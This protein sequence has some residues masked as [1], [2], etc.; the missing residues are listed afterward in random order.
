MVEHFEIAGKKIWI[1]TYPPKR[2]LPPDIDVN[3]TLDELIDLPQDEYSR[4]YYERSG[5]FLG[6]FDTREEAD[7]ADPYRFARKFIPGGKLPWE[8]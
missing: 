1:P 3:M 2:L 5:R 7:Q 4:I 8:T 6:I